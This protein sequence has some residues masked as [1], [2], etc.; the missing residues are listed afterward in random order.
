MSIQGFKLNLVNKKGPAVKVRP[1]AEPQP[2]EIWDM[3]MVFKK[4]AEAKL[5]KIMQFCLLDDMQ[6]HSWVMLGDLEIGTFI[7]WLTIFIGMPCWYC[8]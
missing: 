2:T 1:Q 5:T 4:N 3:W 8:F 6:T 7:L